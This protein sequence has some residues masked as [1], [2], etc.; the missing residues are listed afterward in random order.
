MK[1]RTVRLILIGVMALAAAQ[2]VKPIGSVAEP[3]PIPTRDFFADSSVD[4]AVRQALERSCA[5]CHSNRD[6]LP[7]Y[8]H[9]APMSWLIGR[10]IARGRL[11][12]NLSEWP[13]NSRNLK[14]DI[15][16]SIDKEEMPLPSYLW[17]HRAAR[18]TQAEKA[19]IDRW[20]DM[21]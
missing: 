5:D 17:M 2:L 8:G 12:L 1:K 19:A 21:P 9:V 10:H 18:L 11:K 6:D 16:D 15:A 14:Q 3:R 4:P 20:A 7:W 13:Q